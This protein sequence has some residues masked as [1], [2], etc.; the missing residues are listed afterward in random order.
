MFSKAARTR[1]LLTALLLMISGCGRSRDVPAVAATQPGILQANPSVELRI[2]GTPNVFYLDVYQVALP[3][4]SVS[5][6][7]EF[8]RPLD[9]GRLDPAPEDLLLKNGI[10]V[11]VGSSRNWDYF[12]AII[13]RHPHAAQSGSAVATGLGEVEIVMKKNVTSQDIFVLSDVNRLTGRTYDNCSDLLAVSFWPDPRH[14]G[15][16]LIAVSPTIRSTRTRLE[17]TLRN[18]E[19]YVTETTP[20]YLYANLNVRLAISTEQFLVMGLSSEGAWST[21]LGHQ[22]LTL[23]GGSE[24][25]EQ[26]LIFVPRLNNRRAPATTR[27]VL[28]VDAGGP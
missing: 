2:P 3:L 1:F 20:E 6:N 12:K 4:G 17:F 22:F 14:P 25:Q 8:W 7:A 15:E 19:R 13:E 27:S 23:E 5:Q 26:V 11:G 18:E 9:E 16:M 21:R 28:N 10:R 24:K